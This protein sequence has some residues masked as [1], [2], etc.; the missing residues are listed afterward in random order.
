M[1]R[2]VTYT[3]LFMLLA[4]STLGVGEYIVRNMPNSYSY[5]HRWM[6]DN[7]SQLEYLILGSSHTYYGFLPSAFFDNSFNLANVSQNPEYDLLLLKKYL[8]LC[9]RLHTVVIPVSYFTFFDKPF[10]QG[11]E[12]HF[13]I[14]YKLYMGVD[15]HSNLSK[16]NF[17]ISNRPVYSGKLLSFLKGKELPMCDTLG[18]GVGYTIDD[19]ASTWKYDAQYIVKR[20]TAVNWDEF[21]GNLDNLRKVAQFC[22]EN[23][24]RLILVTTPTAE[25]YYTLLD[26]AQLEKTYSAITGLCNDYSLNYYNYMTDIRFNDDDFHDGDHLSDIGAQKFTTILKEDFLKE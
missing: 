12:W 13:A 15:K 9:K 4:G 7:A 14:N 18:F 19:K 16:Y 25:S 17:E 24:L 22:K 3:L 20:H 11:S 26:K 1:K 23:D 5:K 6:L 2:F 8:P 10:E 21:D